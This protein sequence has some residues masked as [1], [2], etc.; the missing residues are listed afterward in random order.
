MQMLRIHSNNVLTFYDSGANGN[1]IC[2]KVADDAGLT[3]LD[4]RPKVVTVMGGNMVDI[5]FGIYSC[6]LGPDVDG[7]YHELELQGI[8]QITKA[9][10]LI[11]MVP[12]IQ[13]ASFRLPCQPWPQE[14]VKMLIGL[15]NSHL[16][17][18][19]K[20]ILPS[21]VA[22]YESLL[23]DI[24]RSRLCFGGP[25]VVFTEVYRKTGGHYNLLQ[26]L[27]TES[28]RAF[29]DAPWTFL[30]ENRSE[31]PRKKH[32]LSE[33]FEPAESPKARGTFNLGVPSKEDWPAI[34]R[35]FLPP[36]SV[37]LSGMPL[38]GDAS[39]VEEDVGPVHCPATTQ[40]RMRLHRVTHS[41]CIP[42]VGSLL[43]LVIQS[44]VPM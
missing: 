14:D 23:V 1:L 9:Y 34:G 18:R 29:L 33:E 42:L 21:G 28:A 30:R 8:R 6:T 3:V 11:D 22:M 41:P 39:A 25:H 12:L 36:P 5:G 2:G 26:A 44:R 19:Q 35:S 40:A 15:R 7:Q 17:P 13:E 27:L 4:T 43:I 32:E 38:K 24:H 10:P 31:L 16:Y 37:D 20:F